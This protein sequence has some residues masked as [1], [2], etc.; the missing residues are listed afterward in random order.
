MVARVK[1]RYRMEQPREG[2]RL[3]DHYLLSVTATLAGAL[4]GHRRLDFLEQQV[5]G[6]RALIPLGLRQLGHLAAASHDARR[7]RE[8]GFPLVPR[9]LRRVGDDDVGFVGQHAPYMGPRDG[10]GMGQ[11]CRATPSPSSPTPSSGSVAGSG[12][13]NGG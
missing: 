3:P 13:P 1:F 4:H 11:R 8:G 7:H 6:I 10:L 5:C 12:T 2:A 9:V